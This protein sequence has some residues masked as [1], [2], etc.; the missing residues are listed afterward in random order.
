MNLNASS[1]LNSTLP[2]VCKP[3][4]DGSYFILVAYVCSLIGLLGIPANALT[5]CVLKMDQKKS[6]TRY[7]MLVLATQ[8]TLLIILYSIYYILPL[9]Y[10]RFGWFSSSIQYL[11]SAD[12][13]IL[14]LLSWFKFAEGYTIVS[15]S[16]DRFVALRYPFKSASVCTVSNA[17]RSQMIIW[18]VGLATKLPNLIL[19]FCYYDWKKKCDACEPIF[20]SYPWYTWYRL[21]Y[22]QLIDQIITFL[23]PLLSLL[24][25]NVYLVWQLQNINTFKCTQVKPT[26]CQASETSSETHTCSTRYV[27]GIRAPPRL[28]RLDHYQQC[29]NRV[30]E[31]SLN[32]QSELNRQRRRN[33]QT[34]NTSAMLICVISV[35]IVCETPT[36]LY[37]F[38]DLHSMIW[39]KEQERQPSL[40]LYTIALFTAMLNFASNFLIYGL[41]GRRFRW[42]LRNLFFRWSYMCAHCERPIRRPQKRLQPIRTRPQQTACYSTNN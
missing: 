2:V 7:F 6:T 25:V 14:F 3:G 36:A 16:I 19:D 21:I 34:R 4:L 42:L 8:D 41:V 17:K 33:H 32:A 11:W 23:I 30:N 1:I 9:L 12:A 20:L 22:V 26:K 10:G 15:I 29:N 24:F 27:M 39:I 37:F 35:F 31:S 5:I 38:R 18:T 28:G 13:P 40:A